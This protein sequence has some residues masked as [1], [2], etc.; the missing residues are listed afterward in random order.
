MGG[1]AD[2]QRARRLVWLRW[3]RPDSGGGFGRGVGLL[4]ACLADAVPC[5]ACLLALPDRPRSATVLSCAASSLR[6]G[7][8]YRVFALGPG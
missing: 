6:F 4:V 8:A 3:L 2:G 7:I 5:F 1:G